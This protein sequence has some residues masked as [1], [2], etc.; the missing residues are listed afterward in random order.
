MF[1]SAIRNPGNYYYKAVAN[2]WTAPQNDDLWQDAVKTLFDPCP[3]GWRVPR[4]GEEKLSPWQAYTN[5][6]TTW[7]GAGVDAGRRLPTVIANANSWCPGDGW[8][9]GANAKQAN[10]TQVSYFWTATAWETSAV[11]PSFDERYV[12]PF[13]VAGT[14]RGNGYPIRCVRE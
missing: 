14:G 1:F 4:G 12:A 5:T 6:N 10:M 9:S 2:D 7:E 8:R 13:G 11:R 3:A